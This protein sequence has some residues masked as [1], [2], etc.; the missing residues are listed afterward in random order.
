M[1][2]DTV[3]GVWTYALELARPLTEAGV[4]VAIA[5]MGAPLS[6]TQRADANRIPN[7][8]IHESQYKLEWMREPWGDVDE[9]SNWLLKLAG[10]FRPDVVHLNGFAHGALQWPA[11]VVVVAHSC[12]LSWWKAV[13]GNEA[14]SEWTTYRARVAAGLR[15]AHAVVAPSQAMLE[16]VQHYYGPLRRTQV[17]YNCRRSSQSYTTEKQPYVFSAGRFWDEAKNIAALDG[18]ARLTQ[19]PVYVAGEF[20]RPQGGRSEARSVKLLGQLGTPE[21]QR[22]M[23]NAAIFALPAKYEP[24]GLSALEAALAGCALV[25][26][27]IPSLRE[28]WGDAALYVHPNDAAALAESINTLASNPGLYKRFAR[29]ARTRAYDFTPDQTATAYYQLYMQLIE[30]RAGVLADP[31]GFT[32]TALKPHTPGTFVPAQ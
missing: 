22:W 14:G 15:A 19:W 24:F 31:Y 1:T 30:Q 21:L 7:L 26:G 29:A 27:D 5:T 12:V 13:K 23:T 20:R 9:A 8:I 10:A 3:G 16:S 18:A 25:L 32:H 11:P 2:A 6:S 28:I 17:I 4:Q